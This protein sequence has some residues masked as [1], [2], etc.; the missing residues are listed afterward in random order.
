MRLAVL[1]AALLLFARPAAAEGIDLVY[2]R[3]PGW[4]EQRNE[5]G[6][7]LSFLQNVQE[8]TDMYGVRNVR[9]LIFPSQPPRGSLVATYHAL[10]AEFVAPSFVTSFP[11][12]PIRRR[13]ASGL[14]CAFDG[15]TM[16]AK[17]G[18]EM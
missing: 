10:W 9:V 14:A 5:G 6:I 4:T 18:L 16:K 17:N 1:A 15:E 13:L 8:G 11:V 12:A 2:E 3:P 7:T